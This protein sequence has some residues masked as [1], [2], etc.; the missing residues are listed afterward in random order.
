[1]P[2]CIACKSPDHRIKFDLEDQ[3]GDCYQLLKCEACNC[4]YLNPPPNE[5]Q[6]Q[7]AYDEAYYGEGEENKKFSPLVERTLNIFR[8]AKAKKL[9]RKLKPG[10]RFLD[11]GCGDGELL[12][13]LAKQSDYELFGLEIPGKAAERAVRREGIHLIIGELR[14]V[15][16]PEDHFDGISLIHVFEH[17]SDPTE[18]LQLISTI[19]KKGGRLIIEQ[20][21][22]ESWQAKN[23]KDKWLHLDPPRHLNL[24][25][26]KALKKLLNQHGFKCVSESYFS[27]QFS[28]FGVQQSLLNLICKKREVLYEHLKGSKE[29]VKGYSKLNLFMQKLF[30]WLTF[31][32]FVLT[33]LIASIFG[34]GGTMKMVFLRS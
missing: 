19:L 26:P 16:L 27:P 18:S 13:Q 17:L 29:Y 14:T 2:K 32:L 4:H 9:S 24:M 31:P 8:A 6:L 10:G 7:R 34:K 20:P 22:I 21:N 30:H 28:P 15:N 23:F 11:I 25:G 1:M 3:Y 12:M 5:W 33:D